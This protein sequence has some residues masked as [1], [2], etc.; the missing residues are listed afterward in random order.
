MAIDWNLLREHCVCRRCSKIRLRAIVTFWHMTQEQNGQLKQTK[1]EVGT[2]AC[3]VG[4]DLSTKQHTVGPFHGSLYPT[5]CFGPLF[6]TFVS[7]VCL[8]R[9]THAS[10]WTA[11]LPW[12]VFVCCLIGSA[13]HW[14]CHQQVNKAQRK[15]LSVPCTTWTYLLFCHYCWL[16]RFCWAFKMCST[17]TKHNVNQAEMQSGSV[18]WD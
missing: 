10:K 5:D 18:Y 16:L 15:E 9:G 11:C 6:R 2:S 1:G 7:D 4:I 8:S 14:H 12:N 13:W 3:G 17:S